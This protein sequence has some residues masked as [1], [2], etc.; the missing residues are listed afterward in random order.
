MADWLSSTWEANWRPFQY[1]NLYRLTMA[2]L[3]FLA[4][5]LPHE[6]LGRLEL[7]A[8]PALV[9]LGSTYLLAII[10]GLMLSIH[11][12]HRFNMQLSLQVMVDACAI[13]LFMYAAGGVASGIGVLLLVALA[14]ASLVGRGRLILFYAALATLA[15]LL[16]QI[17]G[18][19]TRG[20][21]LGSVFQ[22]GILS[23][24]FFATA[25][26]ARLLGQRVMINEDLARRH[27]I[28]LD[29]QIRISQRVVER[30]LD[31]ILIVGR[32]GWILRQNPV[33]GAMLQLPAEPR[34]K[35]GHTA[36]LLEEAWLAWLA[37]VGDE[38]IQFVGPLGQEL[39]ARFEQTTSSEGEVLVFLE[40]VGRIKERAQQLK[41]AALG[42][43]TA[44]IAHEIRNPL[45]SIS[46][47]GELL[48]EE[49][50]GEMQDRLLRILNDNVARLDRIV[51]DILELGRQN[52]AEPESIQ[53]AEFCRDFVD[54]IL[55][56]EGLDGAVVDL[57]VEAAASCCF[58]R[59]HLNQVLW[60][61]VG[62]ALRHSTRTAGAVRIEIV[63][64]ALPGQVE[65]H[66]LDD[67]PGVAESVRE[68]VF[69]P[70]FT[71]HT[72][73]TGLGLFIARELCT[74]NGA[75][76]DLAVNSPGAHFIVV[77]RNDTCL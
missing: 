38:A 17:Y 57:E 53:L 40:D 75:T 41:L 73:G 10:G 46:H 43:L 29:N 45:A 47:A 69:E 32:G 14:A 27:G 23:A 51:G 31:G 28:A 71:T 1:F 16:T 42:R 12:Q 49:R 59:S 20:F 26:L 67:G 44:S 65:L 68:Q 15:V 3:F 8:T 50:R 39:R 61:L 18:V 6:W 22:A 76:L 52:R 74:A 66:V 2:G 56:T 64:G 60:N 5:F 34:G 30:M 58:D 4:M 33:A 13:S 36:P 48:R 62:N 63:A 24:G 7:S 35:L 11:W 37:G 77:G 9:V 55:L 54:R 72:K 70:F 21:E 25:I 19:F